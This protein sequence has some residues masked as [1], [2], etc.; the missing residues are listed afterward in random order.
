MKRYM[1]GCLAAIVALGL[2]SFSLAGKK[3][4]KDTE[5][6]FYVTITRSAGGSLSF[7]NSQVSYF[8]HSAPTDCSGTG[9]Y[10][11]VK[12]LDA[13]VIDNGGINVTLN[14]TQTAQDDVEKL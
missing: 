1:A 4:A 9:H 2:S 7:T 12:F 14:G 13:Q 10:C 3:K 11:A 8:G 5:Y 6:W